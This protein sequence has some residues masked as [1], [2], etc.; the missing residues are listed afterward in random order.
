M[1]NILKSCKNLQQWKI[2]EG[3]KFSFKNLKIKIAQ[4]Q[5]IHSSFFI[6]IHGVIT[7]SNMIFIHH[8]IGSSFLGPVLISVEDFSLSGK[9][10]KIL[11]EALKSEN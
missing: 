5:K 3:K 1:Q 2:I 6:I 8:F 7:V 4:L 10:E 11:S 9:K